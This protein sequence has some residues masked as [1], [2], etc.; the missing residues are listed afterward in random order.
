MLLFITPQ[1]INGVI[2]FMSVM[3][4][5]VGKKSVEQNVIMLTKMSCNPQE[6][7][8]CFL[9]GFGDLFRMIR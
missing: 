6:L 5:R 2:L 7:Y 8:G 3:F 4:N 1:G 9:S